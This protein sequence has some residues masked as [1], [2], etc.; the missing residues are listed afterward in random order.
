MFVTGSL[1]L[2]GGGVGAVFATGLL[3]AGGGRE[4]CGVCYRAPCC[5]VKLPL[6]PCCQFLPH[7][8]LPL[9]PPPPYPLPGCP[10][11]P[12]TTQQWW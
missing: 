10:S 3:A 1:L 8:S 7:T 9:C 11:H 6:T 5:M 4:G 2:V 12:A